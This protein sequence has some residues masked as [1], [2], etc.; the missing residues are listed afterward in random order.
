MNKKIVITLIIRFLIKKI[1][2]LL[3]NKLINEFNEYIMRN[4]QNIIKLK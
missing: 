4:R 2:Q 3:Y 1:D